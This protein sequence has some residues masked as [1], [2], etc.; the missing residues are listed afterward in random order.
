[1]I[2]QRNAVVATH[3]STE[4]ESKAELDRYCDALIFIRKE[5]ADN[6]QDDP[7]KTDSDDEDLPKIPPVFRDD[8]YSNEVLQITLDY[9][10]KLK[11]ANLVGR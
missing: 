11:Q 9:I 7:D 2:L 4:S 1:M 10:R 3:C 8:H 6:K 5:I